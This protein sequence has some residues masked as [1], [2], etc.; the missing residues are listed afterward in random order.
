M[1]AETV[2]RTKQNGEFLLLMFSTCVVL[3]YAFWVCRFNSI[4]FSLKLITLLVYF[5]RGRNAQ[6]LDT[7]IW[8]L[9]LNICSFLFRDGLPRCGKSAVA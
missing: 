1:V 3:L 9:F 5:V 6:T 8:E 2:T 7:E 4:L